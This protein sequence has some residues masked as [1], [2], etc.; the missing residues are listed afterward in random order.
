MRHWHIHDVTGWM[1]T[2]LQTQAY[3]HKKNS[4]LIQN[5]TCNLNP[6][7]AFL[8]NGVILATTSIINIMDFITQLVL[9]SGD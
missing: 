9:P 6:I 5:R 7:L 8:V 3:I 4:E 1:K 2:S